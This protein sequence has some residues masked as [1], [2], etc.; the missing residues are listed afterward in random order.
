MRNTDGVQ[1]MLQEIKANNLKMY[2]NLM[3]NIEDIIE[4]Y[5]QYLFV[6]PLSDDSDESD[7][8][9]ASTPQSKKYKMDEIETILQSFKENVSDGLTKKLPQTFN[10]VHALAL[11][12]IC[13]D[14][15]IPKIENKDSKPLKIDFLNLCQQ[16]FYAVLTFKID[17]LI[18][19]LR[20]EAHLLV[21]SSHKSDPL[22]TLEIG[23]QLL[24]LQ[25]TIKST[26]AQQKQSFNFNVLMSIFNYCQ[27]SNFSIDIKNTILEIYQIIFTD[28]Q[29]EEAKKG[30]SFDYHSI[31]E[32]HATSLIKILI[33]NDH[34]SPS[35]ELIWRICLGLNTGDIDKFITQRKVLINQF[36]S[37]L[38][39]TLH[40]PL[41]NNDQELCRR[42]INNPK[43]LV[44]LTARQL[45]DIIA[46]PS[47]HWI[48][49]LAKR[50]QTIISDE[51]ITLYG[52]SV[53]HANLNLLNYTTPKETKK[54]TSGAMENIANFFSSLISQPPKLTTATTL[55]PQE[56]LKNKLLLMSF[57][58][59]YADYAKNLINEVVPTNSFI[60]SL[61]VSRELLPSL[62]PL[63]VI[64]LFQ[65][66][67]ESAYIAKSTSN[68]P[69]DFMQ[70]RCSIE[71]E[72]LMLRIINDIKLNDVV[73][74][75]QLKEIPFILYELLRF[76]E[77]YEISAP[78]LANLFCTLGHEK[79]LDVLQFLDT[80]SEK[81]EIL[82]INGVFY[83]TFSASH[84]KY[85]VQRNGTK[86]L[87]I[88]LVE[89]LL[90]NALTDLRKQWLT[91]QKVVT[92]TKQYPFL[93]KNAD[94]N[95]YNL[96]IQEHLTPL[97][98]LYEQTSLF[99]NYRDQE[100]NE[101]LLKQWLEDERLR[102]QLKLCPSILN[103]F[104]KSVINACAVDSPFLRQLTR[105]D[106][107]TQFILANLTLLIEKYPDVLENAIN[108][109]Y[110]T[111]QTEALVQLIQKLK[112]DFIATP[113]QNAEDFGVCAEDN[114]PI[115]PI[116]NFAKFMKDNY[117]L[118]IN[119]LK[120][121]A[122]TFP[123]ISD[124][125]A[126]QK[127]IIATADSAALEVEL[128]NSS[129]PTPTL[130]PKSPNKAR[131]NA[132]AQQEL[133]EVIA[134][135]DEEEKVRKKQAD[136][137]KLEETRRDQIQ[138]IER[139][140]QQKTEENNQK[141]KAL[142][143]Q[144]QQLEQQTVQLRQLETEY[145]EK[146]RKFDEE[147]KQ[148]AA[149]LMQLEEQI[150]KQSQE[151]E[152]K[153]KLLAQKRVEAAESFA[154]QQKEMQLQLEKETR[155]RQAQLELMQQKHQREM[156]KLQQAEEE[157]LRQQNEAQEQFD[158]IQLSKQQ[159]LELL[160]G[161]HRQQLEII[162]SEHS[163]EARQM[164]T[165]KTELS[166]KHQQEIAALENEIKKINDDYAAQLKRKREDLDRR[167][168]DTDSLKQKYADE[169]QKRKKDEEERV[170][171][172]EELARKQKSDEEARLKK[173]A[174]EEQ[175]RQESLA[176]RR[177]QDNAQKR[178]TQEEIDRNKKAI[179]DHV[180]RMGQ[181]TELMKKIEESRKQLE[182]QMALLNKRNEELAKL[183]N[184]AEL[185]SRKLKEDEQKIELQI[186]DNELRSADIDLKRQQID[187]A[188]LEQKSLTESLA[189]LE[190]ELAQVSDE[191]L[192]KKNQLE[193]SIK[194]KKAATEREKQNYQLHETQL[195][196]QQ[197]EY[198]QIIAQ[199]EE[200]K[201][202]L[203]S[204]RKQIEQQERSRQKLLLQEEQER[205]TKQKEVEEQQRKNQEQ[206]SQWLVENERKKSELEKALQE[207]GLVQ[208]Q[209]LAR[210][211]EL[212]QIKKEREEQIKRRAEELA[213]LQQMEEKRKQQLV[214]ED[215]QRKI[216]EDRYQQSIEDNQRQ[217][218][219]LNKKVG[220]VETQLQ[221]IQLVKQ[222]LH[223]KQKQIQL[224]EN[225]IA[226]ME[227]ELA[228][229][230]IAL[231]ARQDK[232]EQDH[233]NYEEKQRKLDAA[234][235]LLRD[236]ES[237]LTNQIK[238]AVDTNKQLEERVR[239]AKEDAEQQ[240]LVEKARRKEEEL[241]KKQEENRQ[242][243]KL[244][245]EEAL[246]K[247]QEEEKKR[248]TDDQA[249]LDARRKQL[250]AERA[251][252]QIVDEK[253][254]NRGVV[255]QQSSSPRSLAPS[256]SDAQKLA[257]VGMHKAPTAATPK[258]NLPAIS[259]TSNREKRSS[260]DLDAQQL[261][262]EMQKEAL[263]NSAREVTPA[264]S[265]S[266]NQTPRDRLKKSQRAPIELSNTGFIDI[267]Q[268]EE[269]ELKRKAEEEKRMK[270]K[271]ASNKTIT[272]RPAKK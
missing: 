75:E 117:L 170:K 129:A 77:F 216:R 11:I 17:Y 189:R 118:L 210:E 154:R 134:S 164:N 51:I 80:K 119:K 179:E 52:K 271:E 195:A 251:A 94:N 65:Q 113:H 176:K 111:P 32:E 48:K 160:R 144:S 151:E 163:H 185:L 173:E 122:Y 200:K 177:S 199:T 140:T 171:K 155:E 193:L 247:K 71:Y 222:Q 153:N 96:I 234:E 69:D 192:A 70:F 107:I 12:K 31:N 112:P 46:N 172:A 230:N 249:V 138:R 244:L 156:Q 116:I 57:L 5:L 143:E 79:I 6:D 43:L 158:Q 227:K 123:I 88:Q 135:L 136:L 266:D 19:L 241:K 147:Q 72:W 100:F 130:A 178:A 137:N 169:E 245:D 30:G 157:W 74:Y 44:F 76:S 148:R 258:S 198:Q 213:Q 97:T 81:H 267:M 161:Q 132:T 238:Q 240:Q 105:Q 209:L 229:K 104:D 218:Q 34:K 194:E 133:E 24:E 168:K 53:F 196:R 87:F 261:R 67:E 146:Q 263:L 120:L 182:E 2:N 260:Q 41:N 50:S 84:E 61:G 246:R 38:S 184:E 236:R 254:R 68:H 150:N 235:K 183:T 10:F 265:P 165:Q 264:G 42:V 228:Q 20:N 190:Q 269:E 49:E 1:K 187:A 26:E 206:Y 128:A 191:Q 115:D 125:M 256:P 89:I 93:F 127:L 159:Q 201:K 27:K 162:S 255:L 101:A 73:Y 16:Q 121:S 102:I 124:S 217:L 66:A 7:E 28:L 219:E 197:Q 225:E 90:L 174:E 56:M 139:E 257:L 109:L 152:Q 85:V 202:E 35:G 45:I 23:K 9:D 233:R 58:A 205:N 83:K 21:N 131:I 22:L 180:L 37:L 60:I 167:R 141:M 108:S 224:A 220:E 14:D 3:Q 78:I 252:L 223:E 188:A 166:A 232:F 149:E 64:A 253:L 39:Y 40:N 91:Q 4:R 8:E 106:V 25:Q 181:N 103:L 99:E 114:L 221:N 63:R 226:T 92:L 98:S 237:Q 175:K 212:A 262:V 82:C 47:L 208:S 242:R 62:E 250:E 59:K 272:A 259:A 110:C 18:C 186:R 239:K 86:S 214:E 204:R 15:K 248:S 231:K 215:R 203:E 268:K 145:A 54:E 33:E 13:I 270:E 126:Q 55:T 243:K 207:Q 142:A 211:K 29:T 36:R 95:A